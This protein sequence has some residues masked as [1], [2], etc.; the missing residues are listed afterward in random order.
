M[1][2]APSSLVKLSQLH[3]F[4][5]APAL[6]ALSP[7]IFL[8]CIHAL[9]AETQEDEKRAMYSRFVLVLAMACIMSKGF[10]S[11]LFT[12]MEKDL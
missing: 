7:Q 10:K 6:L 12:V 3:N 5:V 4:F 1:K 9:A 11:A 8:P 2:E